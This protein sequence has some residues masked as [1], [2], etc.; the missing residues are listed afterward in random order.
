VHRHLGPGFLEKIHQEAL[1]LELA[2]R[3]IRFEREKP[4]AVAYKGVPI[5]G[6]RV[7]PVVAECVIVELKA[8]VNLH[9]VHAVIVPWW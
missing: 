6:Q 1:C 4:I 2:S 8:T 3:G 7:D 5:P 9:V